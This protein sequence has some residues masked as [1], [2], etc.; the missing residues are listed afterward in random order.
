VVEAVVLILGALVLGWTVVLTYKVHKLIETHV[1]MLNIYLSALS[2]FVEF[3]QQQILQMMEAMYYPAPSGE[4][5][6]VYA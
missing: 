5:K 6:G 4:R 2:Q 3:A 1:A